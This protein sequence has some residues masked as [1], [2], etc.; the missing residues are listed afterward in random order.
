MKKRVLRELGK[1]FTHEAKVESVENPVEK[2][3]NEVMDEIVK[4]KR[5]KKKEE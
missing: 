5:R 4:P 1:I 2:V 3:F